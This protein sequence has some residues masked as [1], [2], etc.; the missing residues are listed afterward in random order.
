MSFAC[1]DLLI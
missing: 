1:T